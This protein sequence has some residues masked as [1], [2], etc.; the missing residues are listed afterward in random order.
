MGSGARCGH[1]QNTQFPPSRDVSCLAPSA[2]GLQG[3]LEGRGAHS[4]VFQVV[5]GRQSPPAQ[6]KQEEE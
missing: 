1:M 6:R 4:P 2:G 5:E 3:E